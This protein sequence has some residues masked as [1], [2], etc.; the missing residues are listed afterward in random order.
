MDLAM[1]SQA[2]A[3]TLCRSASHSSRWAWRLNQRMHTRRQ[4][5]TQARF[6][7]PADSLAAWMTLSV[8]TRLWAWVTIDSSSSHGTHCSM[9][10][11]RRRATL[12]T[13]SGG[14]CETTC[15]AVC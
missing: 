2:T 6:C 1:T 12:V 5:T 15:S 11:R 14:I 7:S 9:R 10:W 4:K 13:S 3:R 8:M